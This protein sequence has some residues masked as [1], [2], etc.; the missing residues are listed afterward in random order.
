MDSVETYRLI[1][2]KYIQSAKDL[3]T[4]ID[5]TQSGFLQQALRKT[6]E[7]SPYVERAKQLLDNLQLVPKPQNLIDIEEIR[8]IL[9][10]LLASQIKPPT[11]S[12]PP[13]SKTRF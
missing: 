3:V 10:P 13:N 11:I 9:L 4:P 2:P 7:A 1:E 5:V 8:A 6:K 12:L